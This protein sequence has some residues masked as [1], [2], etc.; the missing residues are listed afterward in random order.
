MMN[1]WFQLRSGGNLGCAADGQRCNRRVEGSGW[2]LETRIDCFADN[3]WRQEK[4]RAA[5]ERYKD[6]RWNS[7]GLEYSCLSHGRRQTAVTRDWRAAD[8]QTKRAIERRLNERKRTDWAERTVLCTLCADALSVDV[9][10]IL[11][12]DFIF[13][14]H[15][16]R[17]VDIP[18]RRRGVVT[19]VTA[20]DFICCHRLDLWP[21]LAPILNSLQHVIK[22]VVA[23]VWTI[24]W[25]CVRRSSLR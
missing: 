25:S 20:R 3:V 7:G 22:F 4:W 24:C 14:R 11:A 13:V 10:R 18:K 1:R 17:A 19:V 23:S 12:C 21:F 16:L 6:R 9:A 8:I 2:S 15:R 5:I